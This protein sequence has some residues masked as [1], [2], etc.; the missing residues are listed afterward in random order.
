VTRLLPFENMPAAWTG[1]ED[2]ADTVALVAAGGGAAAA[3]A[4]VTAAG[5]G[6]AAVVSG[7]AAT[8]SGF[9]TPELSGGVCAFA[10]R[11]SVAQAAITMKNVKPSP[12]TKPLALIAL[13]PGSCI[14][15]P[16]GGVVPPLL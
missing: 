1:A 12:C 7:A 13:P 4:G 2:D 11:G 9:A 15:A 10:T 16:R 8:L 6:A 3:G 14:H 5:A